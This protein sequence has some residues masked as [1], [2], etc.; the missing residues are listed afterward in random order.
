MSGPIFS[1]RFT[2]D[3]HLDDAI[4]HNFNVRKARS[5]AHG[6]A[7]S[8]FPV[9]LL[10]DSSMPYEH[11]YYQHSPVLWAQGRL[12]LIPVSLLAEVSYVTEC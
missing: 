12:F 11:Q 5:W 1:S 9:S 8:P 2:V 4:F 7:S 6:P 10:A 3:G